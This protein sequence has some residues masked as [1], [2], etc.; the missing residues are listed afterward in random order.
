[1]AGAAGAAVAGFGAGAVF[2]AAALGTGLVAAEA[3]AAGVLAA[4]VL[5]SRVLGTT[6]RAI[7]RGL[8]VGTFGL[9]QASAANPANPTAKASVTNAL[10]PKAVRRNVGGGTNGV[11][12]FLRGRINQAL[13]P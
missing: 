3:V 5:A 10:V 2:L 6:L 4:R 7:G 9:A 13:K 12:A 11:T 1:M 8:G